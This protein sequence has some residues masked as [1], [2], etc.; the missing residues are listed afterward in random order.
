MS[1]DPN[2]RKAALA[3]LSHIRMNLIET[4]LGSA[5]DR[6]AQIDVNLGKDVAKQQMLKNFIRGLSVIYYFSFLQSNLTDSQW[7]EIKSPSGKQRS[8]FA[9]VDWNK[10][11]ALKYARDCFAHNWEGRVFPAHQQNTKHFM[12]I[13]PSVQNPDFITL[14]GDLIVLGDRATFECLQILKQ[15]IEQGDVR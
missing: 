10:F 2:D 15:I 3:R 11:D 14:N 6:E 4:I 9:N 12:A 1:T 8:S 5:V 7:D 13:L